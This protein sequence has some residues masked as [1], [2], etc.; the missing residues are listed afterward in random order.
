[1]V[2]TSADLAVTFS[3][4]NG[5]DN[6]LWIKNTGGSDIDITI[7]AVTYNGNAVANVYVPTDGITIPAGST[8]EIGIICNADGAFITA[9][10]DLS[11]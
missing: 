9:F 5:S 4:N 10:T 3:V 1:M 2:N 7:S 8:G 6:Y 11:I